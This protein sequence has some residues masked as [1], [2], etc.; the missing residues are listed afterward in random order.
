M[1]SLENFLSIFNE[2]SSY[3]FFISLG[4]SI[5]IAVLG[6]VPSVFVTGANI[7]F[8]GPL[9]GFLI[10]LLGEVVGGVIT[11]YL[12]RYGF[13]SKAESIGDKYRFVNRIIESKGRRAFFLVLEAR[14]IPF[15]PS[16]FVTLAAA[17]SSMEVVGFTL[18]TFIGKI[19]S[20]GLEAL[21]SYQVINIEENFIKLVATLLGIGLIFI[22]LRKKNY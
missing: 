1:L 17:I 21:V 22:T 4:L 11:F 13:K 20:I 19:P 6:V 18:A 2:Y 16:G 14:L 15:V 9:Y 8:F 3:A 7:L 12:Y 5:I 10:S